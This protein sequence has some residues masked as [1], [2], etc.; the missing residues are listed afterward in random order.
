MDFDDI[1]AY[2]PWIYASI[3]A[4]ITLIVSIAGVKYVKYEFKKQKQK[5]E[6]KQQQE[7]QINVQQQKNTNDENTAFINNDQTKNKTQEL[8]Q[9][10]SN[11]QEQEEMKEVQS[12]FD[13]NTHGMKKMWFC[14]L[15]FK[16]VWK[17]RSVYCSMAVH[18]FDVL[19]DVL[20]IIGWFY[21]PDETG[22]NINAKTM[23]I[24][25]I[26]I[27][28]FHKF[29]SVIVFWTK[30][31]SIIRCMLQFFD[32]L[33]FQEIYL[34]HK[35][36]IN[37]FKNKANTDDTDSNNES[38]A[39]ETTST[40]KFV[41]NVE[42][43]FESIPQSVLQLVFI[44]RTGWA[45][46]GQGTFLIISILS[47]LQSIIS[48]TNS[49]LKND[50]V[51][52]AAPKWKKYKERLPPSLP[53]LKHALCRL[54]EVVHRIGLLALF[55]SV[56]G[57]IAFAVLICIELVILTA[58]VAFEIT[59]GVKGLRYNATVDELC[60][61]VQ[62][63]ILIPSELVYSH[64]FDFRI[65]PCIQEDPRADSEAIKNS[66]MCRWSFFCG[67][68]FCCC[69]TPTVLLS[70]L[71]H[72]REKHFLP[73]TFRIG[74]SFEEWFVII[75]WASVRPDRGQF[76]FETQY[77]L[78][79]FIASIICFVIFSQ[80][81][82]LFPD[83]K[84]PGGVAIRSRWGYAFMGE[85]EELRRIKVPN[86]WTP[87]IK[88]LEYERSPSLLQKIGFNVDVT[89]KQRE[90]S[91]WEGRIW[92]CGHA[93]NTWGP[94]GLNYH[95][96]E[97]IYILAPCCA[98]YALAMRHYHIVEWLENKKGCKSHKE[99]FAKQCKYDD[100]CSWARDRLGISNFEEGKTHA[101]DD[102]LKILYKV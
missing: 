66:A 90:V 75:I 34:S 32:L 31:R 99:E 11:T 41:R 36:I 72:K 26:F 61:R 95:S 10:N 38:D 8:E 20:V 5:Q 71:C 80:Y 70:T 47:I 43:I 48:M 76:L 74:V 19:T 13:S 94:N 58:V 102:T 49:V 53:F 46:E 39:I 97:N 101:T 84:L 83:F 98:V 100:M 4:I 79:V 52:M 92:G 87:E 85:L 42:A 88:V 59:T 22:D 33:I 68:M 81:L 12:S 37:E 18:I 55:W 21:Y 96:S 44:I 24:C 1:V 78:F 28:L 27:L 64:G 17:M 7:L 35:K 29:V 15:W 50:N 45:N 54:S 93:L 73:V 65:L 89:S 82:Y 62:S 77:G 6:I 67:G 91:F 3:Q 2:I 86:N 16:I 60:L 14:K 63:L 57:G 51:Y 23:A 40:F 9:T 56:C 25:G 69:Y 30:E